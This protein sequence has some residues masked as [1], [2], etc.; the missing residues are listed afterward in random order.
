MQTTDDQ[1]L[2]I[3]SVDDHVVCPPTVWLDR[4]PARYHD[5]APRVERIQW[6]SSRH[7]GTDVS[8][9]VWHYEKM[10]APIPY[11]SASAGLP[12]SEFDMEPMLFDT[13][14]PGC[15]D[16][17]ERLRDMDSQGVEAALCFPNM[18]VQFCGQRFLKAKDKE[19]A[20]LCLRAYNDWLLE[21]WCG[22][23]AGRLL[24]AV[25]VP[26][27]D[28]DLA[29]DELERN[30]ARGAT[31]MTFSEIPAHLGLPSI[32]C[33]YW[34]PLLAACAAA[35]IVINLHIG[36]NS[37]IGMSSADAPLGVLV[38][39]HFGNSALALSDW[40]TSG[41]FLRH[42]NLKIAL[43][44]GQAGWVP[45]LMSRLDT[46]WSTG[47]AV[48]GFTLPR[49]PSAFL[50]DHVWFCVF[51]DQTVLSHLDIVHP[52]QLC[53]ETDFPHP[54]GS[55]PDTQAAAW[56][57]TKDLSAEDRDRVL[58]RNATDLYRID[59]ARLQELRSNA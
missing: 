7:P 28:V 5:V 15:Y 40:I 11:G 38:A 21:E 49:A 19:L 18:F 31:A 9:D 42:P 30:A 51:D 26:L 47:S 48:A 29:V 53:F 27:W 14:R 35:E 12:P 58:W 2:T 25:L 52:A 3:V 10:R 43:S 34:E 8:A 50:D 55:F 36:S 57:Q 54:D 24:G 44:E 33:G 13:M 45:Y 22:P 6:P 16:V 20:L 23:S 37:K 41:V 17:A 59:T 56:R 4:L 32:H 1:P 39:N 46:F